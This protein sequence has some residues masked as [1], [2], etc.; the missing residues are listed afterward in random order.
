VTDAVIPA[1]T[2]FRSPF[3]GHL[4]GYR[5]ASEATAPGRPAQE[6][7]DAALMEQ[8]RLLLDSPASQDERL[9]HE[10]WSVTRRCCRARTAWTG[11][12]VIPLSRWR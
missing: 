9:I 12:R 6:V 11:I 5:A 4:P 7:Y 8:W 1:V 10:F 2:D 3:I